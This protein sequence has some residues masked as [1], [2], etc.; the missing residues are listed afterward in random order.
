MKLTTNTLII[1]GLAAVVAYMLWKQ[2][3]P[4]TL[5]AQAVPPRAGPPPLPPPSPQPTTEALMKTITEGARQGAQQF[6]SDATVRG[7]NY[8]FGKLG[9]GEN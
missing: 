3:R 7:T 2:S 8:L 4:A 1:G 5:E 9:I 6:V